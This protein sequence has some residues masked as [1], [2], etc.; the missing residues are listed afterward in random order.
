M[1]VFLS[2]IKAV[3]VASYA[4]AS[5][6]VRKHIEKNDLGAGCSSSAPAFT[7]GEILNASGEQIAHVSYNGRVW[8]GSKHD[9]IHSGNNRPLFDPR[10]T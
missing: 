6:E 5:A 3:E 7:G 9:A 4:E 1:R 2:R 8:P 10:R